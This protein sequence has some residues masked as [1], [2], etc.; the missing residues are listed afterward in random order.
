MAASNW[1]WAIKSRAWLASRSLRAVAAVMAEDKSIAALDRG[2]ICLAVAIL[3]AAVW[4]CQAH[5][6]SDL[7]ALPSG[8]GYVSNENR[9]RGG[10]GDA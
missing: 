5:G 9:S 6:V 4:T 3:D 1:A 7:L 10:S 8:H 2:H